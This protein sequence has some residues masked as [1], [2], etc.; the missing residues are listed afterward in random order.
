[1]LHVEFDLPDDIRE[2]ITST[3]KRVMRDVE[4]A[5]TPGND[6]LVVLTFA[7]ALGA[8]Y[9]RSLT[10]LRELLSGPLAPE[11]NV[12]LEGIESRYEG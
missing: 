2:L 12:S 8:G 4:T 7:A 10:S 5:K 1:M 9:T 6:D 11:P 3:I